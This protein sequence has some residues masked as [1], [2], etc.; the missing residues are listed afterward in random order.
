MAP[1]FFFCLRLKDGVSCF[2]Q[3]HSQPE[4]VIQSC[5][6]AIGPDAQLSTN[7]DSLCR[8]LAVCYLSSRGP[9]RDGDV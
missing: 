2:S 7:Q 5:S 6:S 9:V 4:G 1:F 8:V 3:S